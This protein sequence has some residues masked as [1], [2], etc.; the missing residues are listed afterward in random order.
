MTDAEELRARGGRPT[1]RPTP[2]RKARIG[3]VVDYA[4]KELLDGARQ[5]G[6]SQS[7]EAARLIAL[8]KLLENNER[9]LLP[10]ALQHL[11]VEL[12]AAHDAGPGSVVRYLIEKAPDDGERWAVWYQLRSAIESYI[13]NHPMR[14]PDEQREEPAEAEPGKAA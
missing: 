10:P 1:K 8:G 5:Y 13:A 12:I 2:G 4:T 6:R 14:R 3:I 9:W 11:A 7:E